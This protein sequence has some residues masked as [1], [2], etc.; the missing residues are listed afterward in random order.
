MALPTTACFRLLPTQGNQSRW[1]S[2][3]P[4]LSLRLFSR[5]FPSGASRNASPIQPQVTD[6]GGVFSTGKTLHLPQ[7]EGLGCSSGQR[8]DSRSNYAKA[9]VLYE[10][11]ELGRKDLFGRKLVPGGETITGWDP[12]RPPLSASAT[13]KYPEKNVGCKNGKQYLRSFLGV[14]WAI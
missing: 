3:S 14:P 8:D 9:W 10:P 12:H 1:Y 4:S 7:P 2:T 11:Q 13:P 5:E 6:Q